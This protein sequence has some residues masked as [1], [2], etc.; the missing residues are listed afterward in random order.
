MKK[1]F[2]AALTA[3]AM[4]S[5]SYAQDDE[6]EYEEETEEVQ[7]PAKKAAVEEEEEEEEE[8]P[9]PKAAK[10]EKKSEPRVAVDAG[11]GTLGFQLDMVSAFNGDPKFY[12]TYK[13]SSD[14]E[15]SLILG[16]NMHGETEVNNIGYQDDYTALTI[17][18]G[19]DFFLTK[20]LLPISVGAEIIYAGLANDFDAAT[21][22]VIEDKSL[23][24][25]NLLGGFRTEISDHF[26]VTA[27]AGLSIGMYSWSE[28]AFDGSRTDVG[29]KAEAQMGW[30]F[31]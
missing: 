1:M 30:F 6:D 27:K 4:C 21:G 23:I 7:K 20:K 28:G 5:Y 24:E 13:I 11:S 25:I 8:A 2:I 31:L 12:I 18:A 17:G 22:L 26:Y 10:K 29:L 16:L 14:M 19:F 3:M 15:A 9:A